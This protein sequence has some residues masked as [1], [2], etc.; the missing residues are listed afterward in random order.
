MDKRVVEFHILTK[1]LQVILSRVIDILASRGKQF[2]K[3]YLKIA[4]KGVDN[5]IIYI[6]YNLHQGVWVTVGDALYR[7]PKVQ[8]TLC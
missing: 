6:Y 3:I 7:E 8:E 4:L 2:A 1:V 5:Y